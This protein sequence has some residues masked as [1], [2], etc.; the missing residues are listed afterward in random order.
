MTLVELVLV[1]IVEASPRC[2]LLLKRHQHRN[3]QEKCA[4]QLDTN[5]GSFWPIAQEPVQPE[6][7]YTQCHR[8]QFRVGNVEVELKD[9]LS[10]RY[11]DSC[12]DAC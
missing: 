12:G 10:K 7:V 9:V 2:Q 1:C 5:V 8:L 3:L 6:M 11:V 4:Q